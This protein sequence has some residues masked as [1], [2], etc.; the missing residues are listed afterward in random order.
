MI[1]FY[2]LDQYFIKVKK[3]K[4]VSIIGYE[5][6]GW[7][8]EAHLVEEEWNAQSRGN[9]KGRENQIHFGRGNK[10][11]TSIKEV[12]NN[13]TLDTIEWRKIIHVVNYN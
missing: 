3:L 9:K 2:F 1:V 8:G 5:Q 7:S 6:G 11:A 13:M 12:I 10:K 4:S